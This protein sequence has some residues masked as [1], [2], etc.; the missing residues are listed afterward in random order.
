MTSTLPN[1]VAIHSS[2][3]LIPVIL[4]LIDLTL[5][6]SSIREALE[7]GPKT[8][9]EIY[10]QAREGIKLEGERWDAAKKQQEGSKDKALVSVSLRSTMFVANS[11]CL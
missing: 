1:S 8:T 3:Q 11:F 10:R 6:L 4:S 5:Q 9:K 7:E 2:V